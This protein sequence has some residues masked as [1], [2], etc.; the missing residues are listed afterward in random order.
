MSVDD[1]GPPAKKRRF[2]QEETSQ[3]CSVAPLSD[4]HTSPHAPRS[5]IDHFPP[6][7]ERAADALE[8]HENAFDTELLFSF[9]GQRLPPEVVQR[10][11]ELSSDNLERGMF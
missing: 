8:S 3:P 1:L 6:K 5:R 7:D 10:L 4:S 2:F 9:I 11:R